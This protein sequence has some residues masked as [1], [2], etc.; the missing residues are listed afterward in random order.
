MRTSV[1]AD[2]LYVATKEKGKVPGNH[3]TGFFCPERLLSTPG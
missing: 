3:E 2:G 1:Q